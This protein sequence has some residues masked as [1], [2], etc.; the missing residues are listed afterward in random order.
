MYLACSLRL[1]GSLSVDFLQ[2]VCIFLS[3]IPD[4]CLCAERKDKIEEGNRTLVQNFQ[5]QLNQQLESLHK[6][7]SASVTQQ[8]SQLKEM[9]EDMLSFLSS[10]A[11]VSCCTSFENERACLY[12]NF[13]CDLL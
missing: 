9:E 8:E 4:D 7:V 13:C 6:T 2:I 3:M 11:E 5:S 1:V 10:K 12:L